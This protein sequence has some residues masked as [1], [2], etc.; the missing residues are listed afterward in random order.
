MVEKKFGESG[1]RVVIEEFLHGKEVSFI[2]ISDGVKVL[3]FV[4]TMDHKAVYDGDKGPNT[5]GM[6][7]ISPSP[8]VDQDLFNN[9][10]KTIVFPTVTR[11]LE[12]GRKYKGVLYVGL[13]LTEEGPK[14]LEYNCRFGDPET[15]PQM[16]RLESDLVEILMAT[17]EGN[18]LEKEVVWANKP[19]GCVVLAS[20]GYPTKYEKGKQIE[21]LKEATDMPG[22]SLFHAGTEF[23]DN[24]Y[25]TSGGR[26][27]GVCASE[28]TLTSTMNKIYEGIGKISFDAM[29]YRRDI[30]AEREEEQ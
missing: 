18:I 15:Q 9:T 5:G 14:V 13:I 12:E 21:G 4:T 27:L 19:S 29:H 22:V 26:V 25:Y 23:K 10:V 7:A 20:G 3:P 6:G 16:L 1:N 28:E 8:F 2:V 11:M 17:V 30:G 24:K